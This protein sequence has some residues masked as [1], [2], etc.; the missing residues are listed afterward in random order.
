M[1]LAVVKVA[2]RQLAANREQL[3]QVQVAAAAFGPI[4]KV[5]T[6]AQV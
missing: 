4:L 5:V 2:Q 1:R 6:A 3:I